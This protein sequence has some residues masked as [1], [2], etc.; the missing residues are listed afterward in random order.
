MNNKRQTIWLVSMLSLMVVLSA[1]YLFTED[2]D[3][4]DFNAKGA[5]PKEVTISA[6]EL[7]SHPNTGTGAAAQTGAA[8]DAKPGTKPEAQPDTRSEG[9]TETKSEGKTEGK[10][11]GKSESK[12]DSRSEGKTETKQEGKSEGKPEGKSDGKTSPSTD[13]SKQTTPSADPKASSTKTDTPSSA[14]P[15]SKAASDSSADAKVLEKMQSKATS[16]TDYFVGL[17]MKRNEDMSKQVEQYI[18]ILADTTQTK[19]AAA[20]AEADMR[21]LQDLETKMTNLEETLMKDYHQA[22]VTQD[23]G[24]Y[25]VTVQANKLEKSQAL[26]IA[27]LTM[28]ELGI[29]PESISIQYLP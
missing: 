7:D 18:T 21:K 19:E 24:K 9:K 2:V 5:V 3:K 20:K 13:T 1:Y 22:V 11:E 14:Q 27:D 15:V 12:P 25:K 16:G 29:G 10:S 23:S 4:L 6:G 8:T 17:Q 28:K 26:S